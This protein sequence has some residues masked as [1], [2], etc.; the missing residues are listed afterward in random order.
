MTESEV[1]AGLT[2]PYAAVAL[3]GSGGAVAT[4]LIVFM[5]VTS[6]FSAQLIAVSSILTYDIYGTYINPKAS[7][8]RLV[9]IS[10]TCVAG[11][12]IVMA[13]FSTGLYYAG[14]SMG[15]LYVFMGVIISS[16]VLPATLTLMW[17]GQNFW[18][19]T[20]SPILGLMCSLTAW[21]VTTS[22]L[23]DGVI[24]VETSGANNPMLA[25]N[26]VAL[27]SPMVFIPVLTLIFGMGKLLPSNLDIS[28]L[29][30]RQITMIGCP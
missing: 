17:K 30:I 9:Y 15:W 16:A 22:K 29:T 24:S 23:N 13:S 1:T 5:A 6:A 4:L 12:G 14:I 18:A 20:L 19:A 27:L 28:I 3:L 21:L 25:G 10:H 11:W 8:K 26:V 7:G 2:L